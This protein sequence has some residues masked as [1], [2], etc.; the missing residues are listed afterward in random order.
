MQRCG[1]WQKNTTNFVHSSCVARLMQR[2]RSSSG[3][4]VIYMRPCN[5]QTGLE[6]SLLRST[7]F[8]LES[9]TRKYALLWTKSRKLWKRRLRMTKSVLVASVLMALIH[10]FSR[11]KKNLLLLSQRRCRKKSKQFQ[12]LKQNRNPK[13]RSTKVINTTKQR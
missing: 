3:S 13:P 7:T 1:S 6:Q 4:S 11:N 10:S 9:G 5:S 8:A 2:R 12:N